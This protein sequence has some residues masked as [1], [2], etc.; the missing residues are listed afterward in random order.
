MDELELRRRLYADP[1]ASDEDLLKA[2]QDDPDANAFSEE[3]KALDQDI[4]NALA[5]PIPED[6]PQRLVLNQSLDAFQT[7]RK[8]SRVHLAL[9][10]SIAFTFGVGLAHWQAAGPLN[11]EQHALAHVYHET[12]AFINTS[13]EFSLAEV[14][15][16]LA[17]FDAQF[18]QL[19]SKVSYLTF[20]NFKGQKS[21]H[22]VLQTDNG[23]MTLFVVPS[24]NQYQAES[25]FSD[26]QYDGATYQGHK[27]NLILLG[28]KGQPLTPYG[29]KVKSTLNWQI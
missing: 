15:A 5:V 4:A 3:L 13:T 2:L 27:A 1:H 14:N 6:L 8:K 29:D 22:L 20:C 18:E 12:G 24:N 17:S 11:L 23:P 19:P 21:L 16:K 26:Q 28:E 7:Q 9:A 10:A 25:Y